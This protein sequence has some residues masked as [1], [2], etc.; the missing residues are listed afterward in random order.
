[1]CP[2]LIKYLIIPR[3]YYVKFSIFFEQ[4]WDQSNKL[5][6]E[7]KILNCIANISS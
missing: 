6:P 2:K 4:S 7:Q 1:M 5:K 3:N